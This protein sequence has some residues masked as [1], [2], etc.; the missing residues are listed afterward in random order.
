M[1]FSG[2]GVKYSGETFT[3]EQKFLVVKH[4][5]SERLNLFN[6]Y[7]V[8]LWQGSNEAPTH[9]AIVEEFKLRSVLVLGGGRVRRVSAQEMMLYGSSATYDGVPRRFLDF[10]KNSILAGYQQKFPILESIIINTPEKTRND[11]NVSF[12]DK[13]MQTGGAP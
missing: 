2:L 8:D 1:I 5:T 10:F 9:A 4:S 11:N 12:L 13:F 3:G 6:F 7:G